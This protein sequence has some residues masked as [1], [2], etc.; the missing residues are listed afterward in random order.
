MF[1]NNNLKYYLLKKNINNKNLN[2]FL[3]EYFILFIYE[4][5]KIIY[6]IVKFQFQI[7]YK[8]IKFFNFFFSNKNKEILNF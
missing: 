3:F 5:N 1:Y 4:L 7:L 6:F 8:F 2:I